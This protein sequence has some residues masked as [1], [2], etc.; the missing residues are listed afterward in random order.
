MTVHLAMLLALTLSVAG[1]MLGYRRAWAV[2]GGSRKRLHSLPRYH[3]LWVLL[4]MLLPAV[5]YTLVGLAVEGTLID[6][7]VYRGLPEEL[8]AGE[9]RSLLLSRIANIA[10]GRGILVSP[11]PPSRR[12]PTTSIPCRRAP[13]GSWGW[14]PSP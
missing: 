6:W 10:S 9:N 4:C 8:V 2:G 7:L 3:G 14:A 13:T 1:F 5:A 11:V 12:Q